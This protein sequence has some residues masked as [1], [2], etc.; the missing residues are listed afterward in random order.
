MTAADGE[1]GRCSCWAYMTS[2]SLG[3]SHDIE[4]R[5][6]VTR[7][8]SS[9]AGGGGGLAVVPQQRPSLGPVHGE[10]WAVTGA[11][12]DEPHWG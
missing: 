11:V 6:R 2:E 9:L 12:T 10:K 5:T 7:C 1:V 8:V 4:R 3:E